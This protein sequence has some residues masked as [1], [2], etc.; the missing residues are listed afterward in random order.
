MVYQIGVQIAKRQDDQPMM[1]FT[2]L[3][4][5]PHPEFHST[6]LI[7]PIEFKKVVNKTATVVF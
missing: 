4:S 5:K 1:P 7:C 6:S 2:L 3:P